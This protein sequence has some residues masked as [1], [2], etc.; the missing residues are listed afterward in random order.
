M[1]MLMKPTSSQLAL[2]I[3]TLIAENRRTSLSKLVDV[4]ND[5]DLKSCV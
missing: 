5:F 1:Y 2:N 4:E 3:S